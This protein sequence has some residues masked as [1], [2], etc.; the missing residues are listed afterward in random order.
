MNP[1]SHLVAWQVAHEFVL[2]VYR[3]TRTFP[4]EERFELTSQLRRASTSIPTNIAE[5]CGKRGGREL[6]RY[7]DM[8]IGSHSEVTYL[9]MLSRDLGYLTEEQYRALEAKR[10]AAGKLTW[11]LYQASM[12]RGQ[13]T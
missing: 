4:K 1:F 3:A 9:L 11:R 8:A 7:L 12:K 10:N 2:L 5:G 6:R 13:R